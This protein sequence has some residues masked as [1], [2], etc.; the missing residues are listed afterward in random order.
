MST[1]LHQHEKKS[2]F[3]CL[4]AQWCE[5]LYYSPMLNKKHMNH[6]FWD[7]PETSAR[8][9]KRKKKKIYTKRWLKC[10]IVFWKKFLQFLK[11]KVWQNC[12]LWFL[13]SRRFNGCLI[14]EQGSKTILEQCVD[15][16]VTKHFCY[17]CFVNPELLTLKVGIRNPGWDHLVGNPAR[18]SKLL[19]LS[20]KEA[21]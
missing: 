12:W 13:S 16:A 19:L 4:V 11:H 6:T 2:S 21:V 1:K 7:I 17:G 18:R 10:N 15:Y 3:E 5:K 8:K 9:S 20:P 14:G